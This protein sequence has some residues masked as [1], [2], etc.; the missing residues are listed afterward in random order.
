MAAAKQ[1]QQNPAAPAVGKQPRGQAYP[2]LISEGKDVLLLRVPAADAREVQRQIEDGAL[3]NG[4]VNG[5]TAL[6]SSTLP[7]RARVPQAKT[8]DRGGRRAPH[9]T[10]MP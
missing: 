10:H 6:G 7:A 8:L 5:V 4:W 2:Q 3:P 1:P 9:S